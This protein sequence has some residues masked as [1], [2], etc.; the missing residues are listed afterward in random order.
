[1]AVP[2]AVGANALLTETI[3][4]IVS[5]TME[6]GGGPPASDLQIPSLVRERLELQQLEL[7]Q[8]ELR[9]REKRCKSGSSFGIQRYSSPD[10]NILLQDNRLENF[11]C[12]V[13]HVDSWLGIIGVSRRAVLRD[14]KQL[15]NGVELDVITGLNFAFSTRVRTA[16]SDV[17]YLYK[18][19]S[20]AY[21]GIY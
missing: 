18:A 6:D 10:S 2:G 13:V 14:Q 15:V 11:P 5:S 20:A 7:Q 9:F 8:K 3:E 17:R 16:V 12:L 19:L 21:P 1:M 4:T